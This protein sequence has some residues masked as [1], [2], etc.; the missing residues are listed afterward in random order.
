MAKQLVTPKSQVQSED[1]I[2]IDQKNF[3]KMF[4]DIPASEIGDNVALNINMKLKPQY[5]EGRTG[6]REWSSTILPALRTGFTASRVGYLV[7]LTSG[8]VEFADVYNKYFVWPDGDNDEIIEIL[9]DTL[10]SPIQT[11]NLTN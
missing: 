2:R 9:S 4:N 7:T 10:E 3:G 11:K 1:L 6:S 8:V 5:A